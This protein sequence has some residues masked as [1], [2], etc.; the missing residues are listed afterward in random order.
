[1]DKIK[2]LA[3]LLQGKIFLQKSEKFFKN[4]IKVIDNIYFFRYNTLAFVDR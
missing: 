2:F 1:M 4:S 3:H